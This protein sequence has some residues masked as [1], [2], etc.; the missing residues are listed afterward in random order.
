MVGLKWTWAKG[1]AVAGMLAGSCMIGS[2]VKAAEEKMETSAPPAF[3]LNPF[4]LP[5]NFG[6]LSDPKQP[7]EDISDALLG[8]KFSLNNRLRWEHVAQT[9]KDGTSAITNRTR[10][11]YGTK[12]LGGVSAYVELENNTPWDRSD[13]NAAGSQGAPSKAVI[14]DPEEV[15]LNQ[16]YI[17][18]SLKDNIKLDLIVGRQRIIIDDA[19]FIGNV[20]WRQ[21]EQTY[22]AV[23]IITDL[24]VK[25]LQLQYAYIWKVN[26]IFT[27]ESTAAKAPFE[28]QSHIIH[29]SYKFCDA[30]R[31]TAFAYLLDLSNSVSA[32][33][34]NI[35]YGVTGSGKIKLDDTWAF[36]YKM[37]YA[38]QSDYADSTL[39]YDADFFAVDTKFAVKDLGFGGVGYQL[40]GSDN[41]VAAFQ[42]PLGT[43]HAY[44]GWADL[45]LSTPASGLRDLYVYAGTKLPLGIVGKLYYHDFSA[46]QGGGGL[47]NEWD[48]VLVKKI[49][50]NWTVLAKFADYKNGS[51]TV[52]PDTTKFWLETTFAF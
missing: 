33:A 22:D 2:P 43:N 41:G 11:G 39:S 34:S 4:N 38:H 44:Q 28:S 15:E 50:K 35:T 47:G 31:L 3:T 40:L 26:R 5:E 8:G 17:K 19:R 25:N 18:Y 49:N 9:G 52:K 6:W 30:F 37:T 12:P 14:A 13:H 20:G 42:F 32:N 29:G 21:M 23:N 7:A 27:E 10:L 24:G 1:L 46:D 48:A 16:A 51:S 36:D 45:F